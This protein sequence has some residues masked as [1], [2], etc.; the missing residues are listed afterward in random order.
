M[1]TKPPVRSAGWRT[2]LRGSCLQPIRRSS[3]LIRPAKSA[4]SGVRS[5]DSDRREWRVGHNVTEAR[6]ETGVQGLLAPAAGYSEGPCYMI[7][8]VWSTNYQRRPLFSGWSAG[9][10]TR[11]PAAPPPCV[12]RDVAQN[13]SMGRPWAGK[14]HNINDGSSAAACAATGSNTSRASR[15]RPRASPVAG[16]ARLRSSQVDDS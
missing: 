3:I 16:H 8:K 14:L 12:R 7:R 4:R 1:R 2:G 6:R 13:A 10:R 9:R 15:R 5:M 11:R